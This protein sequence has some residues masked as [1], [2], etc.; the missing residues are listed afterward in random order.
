MATYT[1]DRGTVVRER[2]RAALARRPERKRLLLAGALAGV[3]AGLIMGMVAMIRSAAVGA[4]FWL[5]L[6]AMAATY[7]GPMAL[8]NGASAVFVGLLTHMVVSALW[9]TLFGYL[10]DRTTAAGSAVVGGLFFGVAVWFLMTFIALP[11]F[12]PVMRARVAM[13]S[14]W[15]FVYHLIFGASL[16][17]IMPIAKKLRR[18]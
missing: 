3:I 8:V 5:P 18:A 1:T 14:G 2:E 11:I 9:G 16:A 7:M 4:G 6:Q 17:F 13:Y 15:W 12:D 10:V